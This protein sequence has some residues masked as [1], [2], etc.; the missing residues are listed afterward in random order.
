[1]YNHNYIMYR[2]CAPVANFAMIR[3]HNQIQLA[4]ILA[5]SICPYFLDNIVNAH[6]GGICGCLPSATGCEMMYFF[7][8]MPG[9]CSRDRRSCKYGYEAQVQSDVHGRFHENLQLL[10]TGGNYWA[11]VKTVYSPFSSQELDGTLNKICLMLYEKL[12]LKNKNWMKK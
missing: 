7:E 10:P 12:V 6:F 3:V 2:V 9:A 4:Q 5:Q 1:M 8:R 11:L